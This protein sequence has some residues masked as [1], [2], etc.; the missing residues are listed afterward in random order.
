MGSPAAWHR[1]CRPANGRRNLPAATHRSH[2]R[3]FTSAGGALAGAGRS[4]QYRGRRNG[5]F[6]VDK[7]PVGRQCATGVALSVRRQGEA[8]Q[9]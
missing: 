6:D 4:L 1:E 2:P 5:R 9:L 8:G 7:M 3:G